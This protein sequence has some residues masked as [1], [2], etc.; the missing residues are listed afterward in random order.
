MGFAVAYFNTPL[1]GIFL[2]NESVLSEY[3]DMECG[4]GEFWSLQF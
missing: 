1:N 3:S 4:N 2:V